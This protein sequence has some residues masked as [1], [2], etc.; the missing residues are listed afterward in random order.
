MTEGSTARDFHPSGFF[1]LRT[2]LLPCDE[3]LEWSAGPKAV[4][5]SFAADRTLLRERL[6][7]A[8]ARPEIKEALFVAS[9]RIETELFG[10]EGSDGF[11]DVKVERAVARYFSR[12]SARPTPFGLFAGCS[13]GVI[14]DETI[15]EIG[16]RAGY[17]KH[18]RLDMEYLSALADELERDLDTRRSLTYR[19]NSSIYRSG[20][21]LRYAEARTS[22]GVRSHHLVAVEETPYLLETLRR[23]GNGAPAADLAAALVDDDVTHE[24]AEQFIW[25]LID[26]QI[27]VSDFA[28]PITGAEPI[29]ALIPQ[30]EAHAATAKAAEV[31]DEA[32]TAMADIDAAGL[33]VA[34]D[35]YHEVAGALERLPAKI[36]I[37]RLFQVD[38]TKPV[39]T[40][41][42]GH[43]VV[44]EIDKAVRILHRIG[45]KVFAEDSMA[46]FRAAF[47]ERYGDREVG[48]LEALDE[49]VGIGFEASR[50]PSAEASPLLAGLVFPAAPDERVTW[51]RR[52]E[53]LLRKLIDATASGSMEIDLTTSDIEDMA[54]DPPP[55]PGAFSAGVV[56]ATQSRTDFDKGDF[57][58]LLQGVYGPSG[59]RLLGRFC[60]ADDL[61]K[62]QVKAHLHEEEALEPDA[63][64][65][66]IVHL[67]EG[68]LGNILLR[69]VL[70]D[71]EIE[72]LGRGGAGKDALIAVDDLTVSIVGERVV[73]RSKARGREVVP[74]LTNAHNYTYRSLGVYRFLCALQSQQVAGG[75]AWNWGPVDNTPF[76]PRVRHG[77]LLFARARWMI[78]VGELPAMSGELTSAQWDALQEWRE[79]RRIP[80]FVA[81]ADADNELPVD[82]NNVMLVE[83]FLSLVK[84]RQWARLVEMWPPP[85]DLCVQGPEGSFTHEILVPFVAD[86][87]LK[88]RAR[89]DRWRSSQVPRSFPPGSEWLYAK[90]YTGTATADKVIR[91]LAAPV[92]DAALSSG[93]ADSWF[94]VRYGDPEWH[95]R[96]R[97]HG[98]PD[99]LRDEVLPDLTDR[100]GRLLDDGLI[101]RLQLDTYEREL[102][103]YGGGRAVELAERIFYADSRTVAAIVAMLKGDEGMDARWRL[104]LRGVDLLM[105]DFRLAVED[106][107]AV[108]G[109]L[110]DSFGE[111]FEV[112]P[113]L[114]RQLGQKYRNERANL[115][116]LLAGDTEH[117]LGPGLRLLAERSQYISEA[118]E[119]LWHLEDEG[120]VTRS[121]PEIVSSLVHMHANRLLRSAA[122]AQELVIYEFLVR[123]Y[124]AQI[125]RAESGG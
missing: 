72:Y 68:R 111:E 99:R 117:G 120:E 8:V 30:L 38:M 125:A 20:G 55:L 1:V 112:T 106:R 37:N 124:R 29:H 61:L 3:L 18:T 40:L 95:V 16:S 121:I 48:L 44:D 10:E 32:H 93:A 19:P 110:R 11:K 73:L 71:Y 28:P 69:P 57:R 41:S 31:L 70:R 81:L 85:D 113:D 45:G 56:V 13:T 79:A 9:P 22:Q 58:L 59:A 103:R 43:R 15:L 92:A 39:A 14:A 84:K 36:Q 88:P 24:E 96:V 60:H 86:G 123:L 97:L 78:N 23:S 51:G 50:A 87:P 62:E 35:R 5:A 27:L 46:R 107:H 82:W 33:G 49:E 4:G 119:E 66:E 94:F 63:L 105:E 77:R 52:N 98:S 108:V 91:E 64:F 115:E 101:H 104:T 90:L 83:S 118:A 25:E 47:L 67:P 116:T 109:G 100:A 74:R 102:D 26:S 2:P 34:P 75:L 89:V 76:L 17:R 21:R 80:R 12:M 53:V 65:A 122:R 42:L 114:K 7:G 54:S 6:W